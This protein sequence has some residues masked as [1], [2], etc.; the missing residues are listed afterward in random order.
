MLIEDYAL[1]GDLQTAALI[2]RGGSIDWMCLP[3]LRLRLVLRRSA[4]GSAARTLAAGARGRGGLDLPA[5]PARHPGARDR[6]RDRRREGAGDR[7]HAPPGRWSAALDADRPRV[8]GSGA[9]ANGAAVAAR[10]RSHLA[11][12]RTR[13]RRRG[14]HLGAG[15]VPAQHA[16]AARRAERCRRGRIRRRRGGSGTVCAALAPVAPA[17]PAGRGRRLGARPDRGLVA[18]VERSQH[19]P[20]SVPGPGADLADRAQGDDLGD[21]RRVDRRADHVAAGGPRGS[22]QLG[23]P[24]LLAARLGAGAAGAARRPA[25]PTRRWRSATFCCVPGPATRPRSRSCT[26]SAASDA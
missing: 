15:R 1:I 26:G 11:V 13:A 6:L 5:L 20:R 19:L 25:T 12:D 7:L 10:L 16:F 21:D 2:G 23:L 14:R 24:L 4:R 3:A 17:D 22:A 9:D 8:E 18:R